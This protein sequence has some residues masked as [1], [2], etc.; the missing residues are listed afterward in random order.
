MVSIY[1]SGVAQ[2]EFAVFDDDLAM[3]VEFF[4]DGGRTAFDGKNKPIYPQ[5]EQDRRDFT[6]NGDNHVG[7]AAVWRT[8]QLDF[9]L[10][11]PQVDTGALERGVWAWGGAA[12]GFG[13]FYQ[14]FQ[15]DEIGRCTGW[16]NGRLG[17]D[18]GFVSEGDADPAGGA[19]VLR[20]ECWG[21]ECA[22]GF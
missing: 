11:F 17:A 16:G 15:F 1:V 18:N 2:D 13:I 4:G 14:R 9:W 21:D 10:P 12:G 8:Y 19:M 20:G 6:V 22:G 7:G 5:I 3:R